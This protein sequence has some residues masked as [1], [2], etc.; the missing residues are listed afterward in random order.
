M[1]HAHARPAVIAVRLRSAAF[2][3]LLTLAAIGLFALAQHVLRP[4]NAA[5]PAVVEGQPL[6]SL[7][8]ML[9]RVTPAVVNIHS[10]TVVRVRNPMAEDPFFRH[11]FGL[12]MVPQE[13]VQQ[14]LGSGVIVNA[15]EGL[16]LTNNHVIEGADDIRVTLADG[17]TV[18]AEFVGSDPDTDVGVLRIPAEDLAELPLASGEALRV[19]DFVV[20]VGNP[21]GLGQTVTSG[22]VSALGRSG[23]QGLAYQNFIQTDASI[24]PGNSGGAL[25]NL[26]GELVGINT[27][28]FSPSGGNVGIGFAIPAELANEIMRQLL[29]T[30]RV[31]R[32]SLGIETQAITPQLA[33]MLDVE[34]A[35]GAVVTRVR[36]G[37][38]AAEA[39][40]QPGDVITAIA[41]QPVDSPQTLHNKEGLLPVGEPI[42]LEYLREG[43]S[44]RI[45]LRLKPQLSQLL[46]SALDPRLDGAE[47]TALPQ[48]SRQQGVSG[49]RVERVADGSRA[50]RSGLAAGDLVT[51]VNRFRI[52]SLDTFGEVIE[53]RPQ[54]LALS[55]VRGRRS[56]V[57]VME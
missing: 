50:A 48:R 45:E 13:R 5:L 47:F 28:I 19:G 8:P 23:L 15:R 24:N 56:G 30:G 36:P 46:G 4:A 41:Q 44:Q 21:F 25:V 42:T 52:D 53:M 35:R 6:P 54:Q 33:A 26:R 18:T 7:A 49:I 9:E 57:V 14:S 3:A 20:A 17:R 43:R 29:D 11:F 31:Q 2:G 55:V 51:G 12:P 39:G 34:G 10:K 1:P 37:S 22:I 38:P 27:A 32:G 40:L 16:V